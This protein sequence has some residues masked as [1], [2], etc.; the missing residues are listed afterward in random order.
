MLARD[1][2]PLFR[3]LTHKT[4]TRLFLYWSG[5][6]DGVAG[7]RHPEWALL[8]A[9][10]QPFR[11]FANLLPS[12]MSCTGMCPQGPFFDEWVTVQLRQVFKMADPDGMWI[13]GTW[14]PPCYCPRCVARFR[15]ETGYQ[16]AVPSGWDWIRYWAKVLFEFRRKFL[17]FLRS[18]KPQCLVS[19]GNISVRR[20]FREDRDWCSGDWYS[21]NQHR[22]AQSLAMR[23]YATTGLPAEAWI[24]DTQ[25]IHSMPDFRPRTKSL[26]RILQ[27]GAGILANGGTW[28]Y[29]TFPLG[30][31]A[32]VPHRMRLAKKA[33]DW[34]RKRAH[35][36]LGTRSAAWTAIMEMEPKNL[37]FDEDVWGAGKAMLALHRSPDLI[38]EADFS[39]KLPYDLVVVP[40]QAVVTPEAVIKFEAFVRRGGKLLSTGVSAASVEMQR[41]LG[42][43]LA[44]RGVVEEGHVLLKSGDPVGV[45]A[46]WDKLELHGAET[47]YPLYH[48]WDHGNTKMRGM[49]KNLAIVGLMDEERPVQAG[50][51]AATLRRLGKGVAVHVPTE[52]F[53]IYW[54]YGYP[55]ILEGVR[56]LN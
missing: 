38:E 6:E 53:T 28:T 29:W 44:D 55:S 7:K 30:N 14:M 33:A 5:L 31:G 16:G 48:S 25:V 27:E 17:V 45:F 23:R 49:P 54:R 51:P 41:L 46:P 2:P 22:L 1:L 56:E 24:C 18:L 10:G 8:D 43:K 13:D 50:M 26:S 42:V 19:F 36:C 20:E 21:P 3:E 37:W 40:E 39:E 15:K 35:V 52:L 47:L 11:N 9:S 4:G 32:F 12:E 34:A